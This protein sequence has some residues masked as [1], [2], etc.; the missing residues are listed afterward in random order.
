MNNNYGVIIHPDRFNQIC[1]MTDE[2]RGKVV[3]NMIKTFKGEDITVF[4]DQF[5]DYASEDLCGRVTRDKELSEKQSANG[6]KGG[7]PKGNRNAKTSENN[8]KTTQKQAKTNPN[9]NTNTNTN[10]NIGFKP[11]QFTAGVSKSDID[12]EEL[13]KQLRKN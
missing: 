3:L 1:S 2:Q 7:A 5:L 11:N 4:N 12:F 13:E 9:T 8:P 6:K 10:N